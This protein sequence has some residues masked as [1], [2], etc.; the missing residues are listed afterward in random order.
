MN[1]NKTHQHAI[2]LSLGSNVGDRL[3]FLKQAKGALLPY[4]T[5]EA[6]S[7]VYE[8]SLPSYAG[9]QPLFMNAALWGWTDLDPKGFLYT[10]KDI[11]IFLGRMPTFRFGP[12]TIDI[13]IIFFDDL[14]MHTS[15][16]TIPHPLMA[17]R[18]FV[19]KPLAEV[20]PQWVHPTLH[21]TVRDL[22]DALPKE[23][24]FVFIDAL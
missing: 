2:A 17:E 7:N 8:V 16:L 22:W 12:R 14:V 20:C 6:C 10:A 15:S 3:A 21:K 23:D 24:A 18:A 4:M 1:E 13:D 19:L 5:I 11:E 9:D